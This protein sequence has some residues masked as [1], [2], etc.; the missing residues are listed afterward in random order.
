MLLFCKTW[1]F[2]ERSQPSVA[3]FSFFGHKSINLIYKTIQ[4]R[5][6]VYR[7]KQRT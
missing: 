6:I 3:G 5:D 4:K 2:E 1:W 7:S